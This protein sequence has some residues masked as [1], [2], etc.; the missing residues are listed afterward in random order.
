MLG[1]LVAGADPGGA[2][3]EDGETALTQAG[4]CSAGGMRQPVGCGGQRLE[5]C[6]VRLAQ[7]RD[8][9]RLLA[10]L[11]LLVRAA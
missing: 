8:E 5:R 2:H 10:S 7:Q 1:E 6:S 3:G 9:K 4:Q 11:R